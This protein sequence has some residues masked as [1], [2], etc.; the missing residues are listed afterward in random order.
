MLWREFTSSF[1][2]REISPRAYLIISFLCDVYLYK[3]GLDWFPL[4][5]SGISDSEYLFLFLISV[6]NQGLSVNLI[7]TK[8][9]WML[10][11]TISRYI[12]VFL[13]RLKFMGL[14]STFYNIS[15]ISWRSVLFG[16]GNRSTQR[17]SPTCH[18]ILY[19]VHLAMNAAG[20]YNCTIVVIGTDYT[21]S[22]KCNY[23]TTTTAY[24]VM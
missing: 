20:T 24:I 23:N 1:A 10:L 12:S 7:L 17:K 11:A 22:C 18:Y 6:L 2:L 5:V 14:N 19:R 15:V 21:G 13:Y 3:D 9:E 4:A 16:G 8:F